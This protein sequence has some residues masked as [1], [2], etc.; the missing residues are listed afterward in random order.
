MVYVVN[1]SL[2]IVLWVQ[3]MSYVLILSM[4]VF[5]QKAKISSQWLWAVS[6][7]NLFLIIDSMIIITIP[8]FYKS[9]RIFPS[10]TKNV[11]GEKKTGYPV[12]DFHRNNKQYKINIEDF[13][14]IPLKKNVWVVR[15]TKEAR[16][17]S[18]WFW[19]K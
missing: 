14:Q 10:I 13:L 8:T 5:G 6:I 9:I 12:G 15:V 17:Y 11:E 16:I 19:A 1:S 4:W 18:G 3:H 7:Q 2:Y